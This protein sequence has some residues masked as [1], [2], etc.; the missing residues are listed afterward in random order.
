MGE[1]NNFVKMIL[2]LKGLLG[3]AKYKE[4]MNNFHVYYYWIF[5]NPQNPTFYNN[6]FYVYNKT[7]RLHMFTLNLIEWKSF[8]S[9]PNF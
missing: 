1:W 7:S 6:N 2:N 5:L 9:K 4:L 8:G 3:I